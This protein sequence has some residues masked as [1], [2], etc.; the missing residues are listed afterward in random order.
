MVVALAVPRPPR[1]FATVERRKSNKIKLHCA[2]I[3]FRFM[4]HRSPASGTSKLKHF[5]LYGKVHDDY[6]IKTQSGGIISLVSMLIM[7]L[8]FLSELQSYLRAEILDHIVVDTTLNQKLPIGLNITFPHIRCDEVS[9]DTVDSKGENQVDIAGTLTKVN[10]DLA[11]APSKGDPVAKPGECFSCLEAQDLAQK[12][13]KLCCNTC[14]DLK[15]TYQDFGLPYFHILDSAMQCRNSVGCRVHGDVLV[16]KVGGNVHVALGKS[17]A[18][19]PLFFCAAWSMFSMMEVLTESG[20]DHIKKHQYK[21]GKYTPLDNFLNPYWLRLAEA[22]PRWVAPNLV[23]LVG[24][25]PLVITYGLSCW[26]SPS[27]ETPPP[28]WLMLC[29][30]GALFFYQTFDAMDGKQA[31]RTGSSSPLGQLFDHGCDC[32]ACIAQVNAGDGWEGI[33]NGNFSNHKVVL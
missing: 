18:R 22:L 12:G 27:F 4:M 14:Q 8:L 24:F 26:V 19:G 17:T 32:L 29:M 16:S 5:D 31:R 7:A 33:K 3:R 9:V 11:G 25:L 1:H 21:A 20:L 6:R 30:T 2:S 10:L 28:R 15:E 23:T 13:E